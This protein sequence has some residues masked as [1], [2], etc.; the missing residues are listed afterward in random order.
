[1]RKIWFGEE[2]N[3]SNFLGQYFS[4]AIANKLLVEQGTYQMYTEP[5][6]GI[7]L[8][9]YNGKTDIVFTFRSEKEIPYDFRNQEQQKKLLLKQFESMGWRANELQK[10]LLNSTFFYFDKFCQIKMPTWTKG[11]VALVGD[12]GYCASP[13]AGMG[14]SL[15]IVGATTLTDA[16]EKY[17]GDFKRAFEIYETDLCPFVEGGA[18]GC[19][20]NV[21]KTSTTDGRRDTL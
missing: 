12:A 20:R 15:A 19:C 9:A 1:V 3:S 10:E 2:H 7:A 11:R 21:R 14:G 8:Y 16:L 18:S 6:K 13:A 5:N 17:K 4:I